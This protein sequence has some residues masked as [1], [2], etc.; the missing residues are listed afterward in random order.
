MLKIKKESGSAYL[1]IVIVLI[2][3][4]VG[5]LSYFV[6]KRY[7]LSELNDLKK[8]QN[9]TQTSDLVLDKIARDDS[10]GSNLTVSYPS[11]WKLVHEKAVYVYG[12]DDIKTIQSPD[13]NRISSPDGKF[14][15]V[16]SVGGDGPSEM[17][18]SD[19]NT[20]YKIV[21]LET[22]LIPRYTQARF[23]AYIT[24]YEDSLNNDYT[25]FFGAQRNDESVRSV[26]VGDSACGFMST[27]FFNTS[28][29]VQVGDDVPISTLSIRLTDIHD[30][31]DSQLAMIEQA[32]QTNNYKIAKK[33]VQSLYVKK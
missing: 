20:T 9:N 15:V 31:S 17:C 4:L 1:A 11:S 7:I 26:K 5:G 30:S 18:N 12:N 13:V 28:S 27:D 32:M 25:Y 16:L 21:K 8:D 22:D 14:Q 6:W 24:H 3:A 10:T 33:I 19:D 23:V 29:S 2:F